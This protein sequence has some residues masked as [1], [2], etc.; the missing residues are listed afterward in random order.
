MGGWVGGFRTKFVG[1]YQRKFHDSEYFHF[2]FHEQSF[3]SVLWYHLGV[4]IVN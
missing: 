1:S 4:M 2:S 3:R